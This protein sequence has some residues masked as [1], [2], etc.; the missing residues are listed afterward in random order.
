MH[1]L[2][3][4]RPRLVAFIKHDFEDSFCG[5]PVV[6]MGHFLVDGNLIKASLSF[7]FFVDVLFLSKLFYGE[8][9][10]RRTFSI[11]KNF[12]KIPIRVIRLRRRRSFAADCWINQFWFECKTSTLIMVFFRRWGIS[13]TRDG[14]AGTAS[15]LSP[16]GVLVIILLVATPFRY[17]PITFFTLNITKEVSSREVRPKSG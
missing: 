8:T 11:V 7:C 4:N 17:M 5:P 6:S 1:H 9:A 10:K 3:D 13:E 14:E 15:V 12:N 2:T 16:D